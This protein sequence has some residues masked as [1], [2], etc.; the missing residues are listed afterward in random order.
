[1]IKI[2]NLKKNPRIYGNELKE[3]NIIDKPVITKIGYKLI[4]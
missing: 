1:L 2:N 3:I 4:G